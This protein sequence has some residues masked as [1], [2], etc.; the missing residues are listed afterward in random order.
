MENFIY[1]IPTKIYFG[2]NKIQHL[3]EIMN[4]LS[5]RNVLL[6]YGRKSI[7]RSGLYD[8][9]H[10]ILANAQ[11]N[12][13]DLAGIEPNPQVESVRQGVNLCRKNQIDVVLAAGGGSVIDCA[14]TIAAAIDYQ[15]DPWEIVK[16]AKR[17]NHVL[18]IVT[19]PTVAA[20]GSEMDYSA[21]ISNKNTHEKISMGHRDL[22]PRASI[23][24]PQYTFSTPTLQ[25]AAGSAD[26]IAHATEI[27]F[28]KERAIFQEHLAE[29]VLRTCFECTPK[30]IQKSDDYEARASLMWSSCWAMNGLLRWGKPV[31]WVC[32]IIEHEI[33]ALYGTTHGIG[34][35]ILLPAWLD[36]IAKKAPND[37]LE[38]Y[39]KNACIG[40]Q[41][42]KD[43][44]AVSK[45]VEEFFLSIGLPSTLGEIGVPINSFEK[46]ATRAILHID[47]TYVS[48]GKNDILK[49]LHQVE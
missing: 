11:I 22:L 40:I 15:G 41:N 13:C 10:N 49:L 3:T 21:V 16:D 39:A 34:L 45:Y 38:Q 2:K 23:M 47:D 26:I 24:D 9:I 18:P 37:L 12:V 27:Y 1:S 36:F 19:I 7:K 5:A 20:T 31:G 25:T 43:L 30:V 44:S 46:I 14:K 32:H 35:A 29:A 28:S 6:V 48:L 33:S 4:T 17:I 42:T 8:E